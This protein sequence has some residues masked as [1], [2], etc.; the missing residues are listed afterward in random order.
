MAD[1]RAESISEAR[2][3]DDKTSVRLA[4]ATGAEQVTLS[5][6][7]RLASELIDRVAVVNQAIRHAISAPDTLAQ[8]IRAGCNRTGMVLGALSLLPAL[9]G[10]WLW[11][12]SALDSEGWK[13][14]AASLL[15]APIVYAVTWAI[16]WVV[17][18]FVGD[19]DKKPA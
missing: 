11:S 15:A 9:Y 3:A 7:W 17:S 12:A 5:M 10:L 2:V 18:A 4:F 8:R 6:D 16:G 1:F 19:K 14:V 13:F